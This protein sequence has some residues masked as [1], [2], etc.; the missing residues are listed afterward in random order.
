METIGFLALKRL[1]LEHEA[2]RFRACVRLLTIRGVVIATARISKAPC[3]HVV[4][5][6]A[7]KYFHGEPF[8]A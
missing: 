7:L 5:T 3:T 8:K 6:L 1:N 2:L 4:Y